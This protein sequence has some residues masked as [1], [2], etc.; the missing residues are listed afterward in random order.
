MKLSMWSVSTIAWHTGRF[1][2]TLA[3]NIIVVIIEEETNVQMLWKHVSCPYTINTLRMSSLYCQMAE[4]EHFNTQ[5][6]VLSFTMKAQNCCLWHVQVY[7]DTLYSSLEKAWRRELTFTEY[8]TTG[9]HVLGVAP[10]WSPQLPPQQPSTV[11][12]HALRCMCGEWG[13]GS[14]S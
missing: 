14:H 2:W 7:T 6:S 4:L 1:W 12:I 3:I 9:R 10:M 5:N 11:N 8:H 13:L